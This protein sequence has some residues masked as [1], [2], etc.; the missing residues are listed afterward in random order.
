MRKLLVEESLPY[1]LG[2][3]A[4]KWLAWASVRMMFTV[5]WQQIITSLQWVVQKETWLLSTWLPVLTYIP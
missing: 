5:P 3:I 4:K 1:A 2:W